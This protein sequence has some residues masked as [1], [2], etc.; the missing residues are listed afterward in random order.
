MTIIIEAEHILADST[1]T[2]FANYV[3][4]YG[5]VI[6]PAMIDVG[7]NV[8][9]AWRQVS[10]PLGRDLLLSTAESMAAAEQIGPKLLQHKTVVEG[11]PRFAE[12]GFT[13]DEVLK[14]GTPFA[15]ADDRRLQLGAENTG[16]APRCYRLI[17]RRVG[18]A[19]MAAASEALSDL[20]DGLEEAGSWKLFT[21]YQTTY[22]DRREMS[23]IWIADDITR[24]WYPQAASTEA[25]AALDAVTDEASI[26]LLDPLPFSE[27]R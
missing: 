21:A 17:R 24:E 9:G 23:E 6:I 27:A 1:P 7:F 25:L 13:F 10:G 12:L 19:G 15:F 14:N 16:S 22:G 18:V 26:H 2:A 5:E 3:E 11:L 20:A 8:V 4:V